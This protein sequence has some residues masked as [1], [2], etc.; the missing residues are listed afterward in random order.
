MVGFYEIKLACKL[1]LLVKHFKEVVIGEIEL[2]I[3]VIGECV[4]RS[5]QDEKLHDVRKLIRKKYND[6]FVIKLI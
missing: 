1:C 6:I 2:H 4:I 3:F 5:K